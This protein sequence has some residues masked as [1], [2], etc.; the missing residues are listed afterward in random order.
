M[1]LIECLK[2]AVF[3]DQVCVVNINENCQKEY[4]SSTENFTF[5]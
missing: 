5:S 4:S 2:N 3:K 1:T